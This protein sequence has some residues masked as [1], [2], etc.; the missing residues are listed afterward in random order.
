[1]KIAVLVFYCLLFTVSAAAQ[2]PSQA[3][4]IWDPPTK[5]DEWNYLPFSDEK[6]RLDN[7]AI[8]WQNTPHA[9]IY[10]VIYAG[11]KSCAGEAE[12]HWARVRDWLVRK[13]GVPSEKITWVNGGYLEELTLTS[14]IW[15]T[16]LSKPGPPY[17]SLKRSEVK[18]IKG[19]KILRPGK[20][21][22]H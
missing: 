15:P 6:A 22:S 2:N 12:A 1:M 3:P 14:W 9:I 5:F 17:E 21:K 19:C 4:E 10:I 7:L 20:R 8:H 18:I 16:D 11:K 13:R